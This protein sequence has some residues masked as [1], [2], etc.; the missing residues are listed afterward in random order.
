MKIHCVGCKRVSYPCRKL[1]F[2][3]L[4]FILPL[5]AANMVL[6]V[7]MPNMYFWG[8][9]WN[10]FFDVELGFKFVRFGLM[11]FWGLWFRFSKHL[12]SSMIT[13]RFFWFFIRFFISDPELQTNPRH[14]NNFSFNKSYH[15][16]IDLFWNINSPSYDFSLLYYSV[17]KQKL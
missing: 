6:C 8:F 4:F 5:T 2:F 11:C 10:F 15:F 12:A 17:R 7:F 16:N 3:V 13:S 1:I 14:Q 9:V